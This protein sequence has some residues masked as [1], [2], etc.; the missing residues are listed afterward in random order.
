MK[1]LLK[2]FGKIQLA[3]QN[4][5]VTTAAISN[6]AAS[7]LSKVKTAS[8][9]RRMPSALYTD[10]LAGNGLARPEFRQPR[11]RKC[12][13]PHADSSHQKGKV[14]IAGAVMYKSC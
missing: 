4:K 1:K 6:P 9:I 14:V 11:C 5:P 10:G 12:G 8:R 13:N 3:T 7:L 2:L